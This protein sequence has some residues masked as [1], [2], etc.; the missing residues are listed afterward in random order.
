MRNLAI[1]ILLSLGFFS[2]M[3]QSPQRI[4]AMRMLQK[5]DNLV[6]MGHFEDAIFS[7][8]NAI[9]TDNAY[10]E[11]FMKRSSMLQRLGRTTEA[12]RDYETALRL[13]PY[14]AFVLDE[15]AKLN[16]LKS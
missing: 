10:A 8:T 5:G 13:N 16:Y 11:A 14:S 9:A 12:K 15:K 3:A 1:T 6:Q 7:Y 4:E 2:L